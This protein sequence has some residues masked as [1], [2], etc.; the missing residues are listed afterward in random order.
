MP[1]VLFSTFEF[2]WMLGERQVEHMVGLVIGQMNFEQMQLFVNR[3]DEADAV[4]E[5]LKRANAAVCQ[6]AAT[7][8]EFVTNIGGGEDGMIEIVKLLFVEAS[9]DSA[10]ADGELL[11][12]LGVH[13]KSPFCC[14][15]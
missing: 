2:R 14:G 11:G 6:A 9:L 4:Y 8:G 5:E 13:S 3:V 10:L 1:V 15:R 12:Y 7:F